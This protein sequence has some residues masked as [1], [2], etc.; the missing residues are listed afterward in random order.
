M[1][2]TPRAATRAAQL[3]SS[4]LGIHFSSPRKLR[5]KRKTQVMVEVPGQKV[6]QRQLLAKMA[7]LM[8]GPT[9]PQDTSSIQERHTETLALKPD[10]ESA[11]AWEDV[12]HDDDVLPVT[13]STDNCP[14][15]SPSTP[16]RRT[17]PDLI[18]ELTSQ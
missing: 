18:R 5:D 7:S 2:V 14:P 11:D 10:T 13:E 8:A 1:P 6:K 3:T 15:Y 17:Q 16:S 9:Q 4:G 12:F